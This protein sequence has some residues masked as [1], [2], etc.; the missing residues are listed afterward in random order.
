MTGNV[1]RIPPSRQREKPGRAFRWIGK[2][3]KR[4]E[5]PR[6]LAGRGGYIADVAVPGMLHAAV[7]RS[8][9]AHARISLDR[10]ER[11][12]ARCPGSPR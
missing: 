3:M 1:A 10:R 2:N 5:D 4:V 12:P 11:A 6:L 7:L 8:P 9:H